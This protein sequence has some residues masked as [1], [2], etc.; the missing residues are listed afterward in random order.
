MPQLTDVTC[1]APHWS[2]T[3]ETAVEIGSKETTTTVP[4]VGRFEIGLQPHHFITSVR[5]YPLCCFIAAINDRPFDPLLLGLFYSQF[6]FS[7]RHPPAR[8]TS[9]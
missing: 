8:T 3:A 7:A 2:E 6:H 5:Y 4:T 1:T 9:K